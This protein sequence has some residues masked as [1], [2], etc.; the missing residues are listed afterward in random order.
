MKRRPILI[1]LAVL[2]AL[3]GTGAVYAYV[4]T[5]DSRAVNGMKAVSVLVVS[6]EIPVGTPWSSIA[7]GGYVTTESVPA[8]AAPSTAL[9]STTADITPTFMATFAIHT[10]QLLTREMFAAKAATV[11]ALQIPGKLQALTISVPLPA[12]VMG[13]VQN[14]SQVAVYALVQLQHSPNANQQVGTNPIVSKLLIPRV[15]VIAVSQPAPT[16]VS[17]GGPAP[18]GSLL[19]TLA[20]DQQQAERLLVAQKVGDLYLTLLT[21]SSVTAEDGGTIAAGIFSPSLLFT[22]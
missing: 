7:S 14:G 3:I 6:K 18:T 16:S 4:H 13:F 20:V 5:A 1:A 22:R 15:T 8:S 11:G 10:G 17:G 19:V 12:D 21:D 9:S 2:L